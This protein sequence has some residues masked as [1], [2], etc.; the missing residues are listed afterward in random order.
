LTEVITRNRL[1]CA[2]NATDEMAG[3][4][5]VPANGSWARAFKRGTIARFGDRQNANFVWR[6]RKEFAAAVA[7]EMP[8]KNNRRHATRYRQP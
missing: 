3:E 8:C 2:S 1:F 4:P 7:L 6:M 5:A